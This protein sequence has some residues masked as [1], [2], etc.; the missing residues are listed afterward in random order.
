MFCL[1]VLLVDIFYQITPWGYDPGSL[2]DIR[3]LRIED[4]DIFSSILL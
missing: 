4:I 2:S 3:K 1:T